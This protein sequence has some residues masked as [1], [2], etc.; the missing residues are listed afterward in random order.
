[1]NKIIT[2]LIPNYKKEKYIEEY[3]ESCINKININIIITDSSTD[4]SIEKIDKF[5][6]KYNNIEIIHRDTNSKLTTNL[7]NFIGN[8][9]PNACKMYF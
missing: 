3:L 5:R 6:N 9:L 2:I 4:I 1:M 8:G 7:F